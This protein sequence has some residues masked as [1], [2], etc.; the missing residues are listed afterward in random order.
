MCECSKVFPLDSTIIS[1]C[2]LF[3]LVRLIR[4]QEKL[5]DNPFMKLFGAYPMELQLHASSNVIS[6]NA[7]NTTVSHVMKKS[8]LGEASFYENALNT[9]ATS[10]LISWR[11]SQT[12]RGTRSN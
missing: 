10:L 9:R 11:P 4:K 3:S 5:E 7:L 1:F 2:F 12:C 8:K 6:M